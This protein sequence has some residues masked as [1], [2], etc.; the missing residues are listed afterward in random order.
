MLAAM[1]TYQNSLNKLIIGN[2][3]LGSIVNSLVLEK[4]NEMDTKLIDASIQ[5][6]LQLK[7]MY[8]SILS[9]PRKSELCLRLQA[10]IKKLDSCNIMVFSL[11][12]NQCYN[13]TKA[14]GKLL[15]QHE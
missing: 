9:V 8:K 15:S 2:V 3:R 11:L 7:K 12:L 14:S 13:L 1:K 6:E 5:K 10:C 4:S